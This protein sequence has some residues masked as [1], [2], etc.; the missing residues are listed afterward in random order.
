[1]AILTASKKACA[2]NPLKSSTPLGAALAFLGIEGSVPLFHG[3]QGCTSFALVLAVR[4]FKE[5]IPLQTTAMNEASTVLGG[6]DH[7]EEALVN[8]TTRMKPKFIGVA[9]TALVETRGED[10][11]GDLRNIVAKRRELDPVR[12]VF[13]ATPDFEGALE[14]GWAKA[15]SAIIEALVPAQELPR[16]EPDR[17]ERIINILPGVHETPASIEALLQLA[18]AFGLRG[19]VVPDISGSL[20]GHLPDAY[21]GTSLGGAPLAEV[22]QLGTALHTLALGEHM[23]AP[24]ELLR[25]RTGVAATVLPTWI[26]LHA[27]DQLV[28]WLSVISGQPAPAWVRRQRSQ[29]VDA[30][31]D[32]HFH[33]SGKRIALAS[34]PDLLHGLAHFFSALGAQV[35]I[36]ISSTQNSPLLTDLPCEEVLVGDLGDLEERAAAAGVDLLVTHSHGRQASEKLGIPLFRVGFPIFDRLGHQHRCLG[37]YA[38]TRELIYEIANLF[39]ARLH[40]HSPEDFGSAVPPL[41][42]MDSR[43]A[44]P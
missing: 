16:A 41:N 44:D 17:A 28:H 23:R 36:A 14:D 15:T 6:S 11:A 12:V 26:G 13:A 32:G 1:M 3:S 31:L 24:A 43:H 25:Q 8:I 7:F 38:G 35:V 18:A 21:V 34:D 42:V 19:R 29:L 10:F 33:F 30:M 20:D 9:S 4:H 27:S 39:L 22:E 37:G 40:E 2:E 5:A